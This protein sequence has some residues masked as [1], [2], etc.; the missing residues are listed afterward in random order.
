MVV[1]YSDVRTKVTVHKNLKLGI[2]RCYF[3][4]TARK[5]AIDGISDVQNFGCFLNI[6]SGIGLLKIVFL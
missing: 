6:P 5:W 3:W 4:K 1:T 2:F